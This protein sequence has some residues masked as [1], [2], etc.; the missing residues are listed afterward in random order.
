M[1]ICEPFWA[2]LDPFGQF[3]AKMIFLLKST[4]AKPR[5][6][7]NSFLPE[8]VQKC[9]DGPKRV[10]NCQKHLGLPFRTLLDPF[11]P[12]WNGDKPAI[13]AIFVLLVRVFGTHCSFLFWLCIYIDFN[14]L[15]CTLKSSRQTSNVMRQFVDSIFL[16]FSCGLWSGDSNCW[17]TDIGGIRQPALGARNRIYPIVQQEQQL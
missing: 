12:L 14:F 16:F 13:L 7:T 8:M 17:Q 6:D 15:G 1:T 10:P 3:Q 4:S 9:P 11:G 2:H 5:G